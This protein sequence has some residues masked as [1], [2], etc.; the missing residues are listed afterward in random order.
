M[1][2]FYVA[3]DA[4]NSPVTI[5]DIA[6]ED[7]KVSLEAELESLPAE[8]SQSERKTEDEAADDE[9]RQLE[10]IGKPTENKVEQGKQNK[11]SLLQNIENVALEHNILVNKWSVIQ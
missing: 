9:E 4:E 5:D 3:A 1:Q 2:Y 8:A 7:S 11:K 6:T 10:R